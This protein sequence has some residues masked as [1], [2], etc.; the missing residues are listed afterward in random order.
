VVERSET[1]FP[2]VVNHR[3]SGAIDESADILDPVAGG[4]RSFR[5][6]VIHIA[7]L[8]NEVLD[9]HV[10]ARRFRALAQLGDDLDEIGETFARCSAEDCLDVLSRGGVEQRHSKL[11]RASSQ[12]VDRGI[13]DSA[14][15]DRDRATKSLF[16][17][18]IC[19]ELEIRHEVA[20]LAPVVEPHR[21]DEPILH[22]LSAQS[23]FQGA[24]LRVG[25][26]QNGEISE[27]PVLLSAARFNLLDYEIGLVPFVQRRDDGYRLARFAGGTQGL[28]L[29]ADVLRDRRICDVKNVGRRPVIL[30]QAYQFRRLELFFKIQ[31]VPDV[32]A[33]PAINRLVVVS[34][35]YDITMG[36]AQQ[37]DELKLRSVRVLVFVN[38][39]ELKAIAIAG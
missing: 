33:T 35:D 5:L 3:L 7:D 8:G 14:L 26:V 4:F 9:E 18:G 30:L 31:N 22:C 32:R 34:N 20:Y 27:A 23:V 28:P 37:F 1:H 39:D 11:P 15:R 13:A 6:D 25:S 12:C 10:H 17:G 29:P 21:S 19:D 24:A 38:E 36:A 16:I 2:P